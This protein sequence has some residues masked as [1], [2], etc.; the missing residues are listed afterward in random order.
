MIRLNE[1][2]LL[3]ASQDRTLC[4]RDASRDHL[5]IGFKQGDLVKSMPSDRRG[6]CRERGDIV[7]RGFWQGESI[8]VAPFVGFSFRRKKILLGRRRCVSGDIRIL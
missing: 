1:T 7:Y 5:S 4:V 8:S 6:R 2:Q 3:Q